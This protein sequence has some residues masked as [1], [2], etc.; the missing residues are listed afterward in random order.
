MVEEFDDINQKFLE[1]SNFDWLRYLLFIFKSVSKR[2]LWK[3][4]FA[5][6]SNSSAYSPLDQYQKILLEDFN[7]VWRTC[8]EVKL[9]LE[10]YLK[11][12]CFNS[13]KKNYSSNIS[14]WQK[15]SK[16]C[17]RMMKKWR[18]LLQEYILILNKLFKSHIH[19]PLSNQYWNWSLLKLFA[20]LQLN[21]LL[22]A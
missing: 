13:K 2:K 9:R 19:I 3:D 6:A 18:L 1:R 14:R 4:T 5:V 17:N 10:F 21:H 16:P 8:L 22:G 15:I 12:K 7:S 20:I 11:K